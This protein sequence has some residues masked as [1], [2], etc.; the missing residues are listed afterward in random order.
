M[1]LLFIALALAMDALAVS[2]VYGSQYKHHLHFSNAFKIALFLGLSQILMPLIGYYLGSYISSYI[3]RFEPFIVFFVFV[4]LGYDMIKHAKDAKKS[5]LKTGTLL[6]LALATSIDALAVGFTFSLENINIWYAIIVIGSMTFFA[7]IL[8]VYV[9]TRLG[10][11]F[12]EKAE[13]LGGI[14]LILL[15]VET[16]LHKSF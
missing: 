3:Q 10:S 15:G 13:Y 6:L 4:F 11:H 8:G 12:E 7:S 2:L 1:P 5:P 16:I 14:V 9:G